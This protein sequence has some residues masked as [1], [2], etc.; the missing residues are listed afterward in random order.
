MCL[1]DISKEGEP[2]MKFPMLRALMVGNVLEVYDFLLYSLF[3]SILSPLFFPSSDPLAA[4]MTGFSV[5]AVGYAARPIGA[6][7]FGHWGD[8]YGRKKTLMRVL[9]CRVINLSL[10]AYF[11]LI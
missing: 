7:V 10:M 1:Y 11:E 5:F 6:I 8:K 2:L 4:L 9:F 3:V